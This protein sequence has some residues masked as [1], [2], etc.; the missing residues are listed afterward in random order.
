MNNQSL[1]ILVVDVDSTG[2]LLL[3]IALEEV[4]KTEVALTHATR[5][6]EALRC[7]HDNH[8]DAVL[9]HL[10]LPD[11]QGLETFVSDAARASGAFRF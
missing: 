4:R 10:N 5:L 3:K 1:H 7:L 8:F 9:L 11:S 6:D 2:F